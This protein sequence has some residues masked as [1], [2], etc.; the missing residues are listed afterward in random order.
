[1]A[2]SG[3]L[4]FFTPRGRVAN[5][6]DWTMLGLG[7][8]GWAA[9]HI[10]NS[11]LFLLVAAF[12]I[13]LNWSMLWGYMK[14]KASMAVNLKWELASAVVIAGI[15]LSGTIYAVPP[16]STIMVWHDDIK[17]YWEGWAA[18]APV[19]HAEE[20]TLGE[21]SQVIQVSLADATDALTKEGFT[22][23]GPGQ[24]VGAL[25]E[26][27]GAAPNEV[28]AAIQK[29]FPTAGSGPGRGR[30]RGM[31]PGAGSGWGPG[32]QTGEHSP[33]DGAEHGARHGESDGMGAGHGMG[34]GMGMRMGR[35][36]GRGMGW[37]RGE[38][39]PAATAD[40]SSQE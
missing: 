8:E 37:G 6:T 38:H 5:W 23:Q 35:G 16:F 31:G 32:R 19:P 10:N 36:Q 7:K 3:A 39:G 22:V 25:A 4:L 33:G 34:R 9:L 18:R 28:L 29:H 20:Y 26:Q 14:K 12:H 1:M 30:G 24:T 40:E 21:F 15:V 2:F 13:Y 17:N 11:V 27:K